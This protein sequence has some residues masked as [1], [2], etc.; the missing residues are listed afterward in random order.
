MSKMSDDFLRAAITSTKLNEAIGDRSI[1]GSGRTIAQNAWDVLFRAAVAP[2]SQLGS[3][4]RDRVG[5]FDEVVDMLAERGA[6]PADPQEPPL[7]STLRAAG[8]QALL[9][10]SSE[11]RLGHVI[12]ALLRDEFHRGDS[13]LEAMGM[14]SEEAVL[15]WLTEEEEEARIDRS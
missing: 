8:L 13:V 12:L 4:L 11:V 7:E 6:A 2:G 9:L 3:Y 10:N 15:A 5:N 1:G 14:S